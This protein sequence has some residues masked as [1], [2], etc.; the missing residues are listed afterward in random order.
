MQRAAAGEI[1]MLLEGSEPARVMEM[2]VGKNSGYKMIFGL[3]VSLL[4]A[5][6]AYSENLNGTWANDLSVCSKIFVKK[7]NKLSFSEN[8]DFY[9]SG[10][11]INGKE[12]IG[13]LGRCRVTSQKVHGTDIEM[14]AECATDI[15]FSSDKFG[16]RIDGHNKI[17]RFFPS[18]PGMEMPYYRCPR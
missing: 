10:F 2:S 11:I 15:A 16:L 17:T 5:F 14:S 4:C 9:G 3:A 8:A 13:K 18:M 12:L 7:H 6:P 1:E